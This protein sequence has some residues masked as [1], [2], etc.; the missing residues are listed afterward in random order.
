MSAAALLLAL[1]DCTAF[2]QPDQRAYCRAWNSN[3]GHCYNIH[4]ADLR[5]QCRAEVLGEKSLCYSIANATE[6]TECQM[7]ANHR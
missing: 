5:V 4:D 1:V 7:R 3:S 6:R 2:D